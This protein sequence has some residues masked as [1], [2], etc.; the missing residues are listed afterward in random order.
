MLAVY[1]LRHFS[2]ELVEHIA[3]CKS[4]RAV[5]LN[6]EVKRIIGTGNATGLGMAPFLLSHPRLLH[7]WIYIREKAIARVKAIEPTDQ[8]LQL[9]MKWVQRISKYL[10]ENSFVAQEYF[11]DNGELAKRLLVVKDWIHEY[12]QGETM[13]GLAVNNVWDTLATLAKQKISF[14]LEEIVYTIL[15]ELYL[16]DIIDLEDNLNVEEV[17]EVD[18]N[19]TIRE[20]REVIK[21]QY[22]WVFQYDFNKPEEKYYFWYRSEEKEEPRLG[23]RNKDIGEEWELPLNIAK[24]VQQLD[25][26]LNQIDQHQ[27]V[28]SFILLNP[29]Y[30]GIVQRI[31]S[32]IG[33]EYG[34]IQENLT[35]KDLYPLH[36]LRC[37]LSFFGAE[38]FDPKSDKWVRITLFQGAPLV[39]ELDQP[40]TESWVFPSLETSIEEVQNNER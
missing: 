33:Y 4:D 28:A 17:Y 19:M 39:E 1:I 22:D 31:Q 34:E 10:E 16:E 6:P 14:E 2:F 13:D 3:A 5:R 37:K 32:L 11:D 9:A 8:E 7:Q 36:L 18:A 35:S 38:R 29:E 30:K 26:V 27:T 20:L 12:V 40:Y 23:I 15:M 24:K 25:R 21:R